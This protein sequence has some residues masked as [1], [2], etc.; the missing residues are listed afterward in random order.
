MKRWGRVSSCLERHILEGKGL[1]VGRPVVAEMYIIQDHFG[2][3]AFDQ[4][5]QR[6]EDVDVYRAS[7]SSNRRPPRP[8]RKSTRVALY[9]PC[10]G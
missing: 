5:S 9:P 7:P 3:A 2:C 6:L 4:E 8:S 1:R 10:D